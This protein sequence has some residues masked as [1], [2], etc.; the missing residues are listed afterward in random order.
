MTITLDY[1]RDALFDEL[2]MRR[3]RDSY[4]LPE[5]KSPQERFAAVA[6]KFGSDEAHSVRLYDYLSKHWLSASTPIL[7]YG[8]SKK[9]LPISCYLSYNED[10]TK[11]LIDTLSEVNWLSVLGGGVGI[12]M[13]IRSRDEKSTGV[14]PH[15]KVLDSSSLA[16]RQGTTRRGSY[17]V[18]LDI[19]HPDIQQFIEI[20]KTIG[21]PNMRCQ[22]LHHGVNI[23]NAFME[24]INRCTLHPEE[25]DSWP[26]IDPHSKEVKAV[27]SAKALWQD[28]LYIRSKEGE[29]YFIFL[30]T[31]NEALPQHLKDKGLSI[32]GSNLCTEIFLPTDGQRT[33]V[34][35]LASMNL[36]YY[37]E[38]K[39]NQQFHR[40]VLEMLDNA[41]TVFIN[42]APD[43]IS[44]AKLSASL[45]RSVGVGVLGFHT[46]L[47]NNGIAF[48]SALAKSVNIQIFRGIRQ[49]LDKANLELG[50]LR[51][52]APDAVGT[53][54]RCSHV[55]AVA[56][57]ATTSIIMG[58]ISPSIEPIRANVYRQ[59][60]LSGSHTNVNPAFTRWLVSKN[61]SEEEQKDII[62][63]VM[64][65]DGSVQHLEV[66]TEAE[67]YVFKTA[68]EIDQRWV[69]DLAG[70][71]QLEI[72]QGQSVNVF[73]PAKASIP[74]I[75]AVHLMAWK[76]GLKSL[77][78]YRSERV[79]KA[80]SVSVSVDLKSILEESECLACQ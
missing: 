49:K 80:E 62:H 44:R 37:D 58:N 48:E 8:R 53:G 17:A 39:N 19:S 11:G 63:S 24:I 60:T 31:A 50:S 75:H 38:W 47:Q 51:G 22:N 15:L 73:F 45:E 32:K 71:R 33:A 57:T 3:L 67:K 5:E 43:E 9:G 74:Y 40:D 28:L 35:C 23:S 1:T 29:P 79:K 76:R 6:S 12:H 30:D 20:R 66:M 26:L 70:D 21:D 65:N 46:Y 36:T 68:M 69:I 54:K 52:E 72:D 25:D 59:D 4:M 27:V 2:G 61:F 56:P 16:Y 77:Y 13:G 64:V 34:C 14:M 7:S 18:F 55:M 42:D 41:L 78:Y 10:T